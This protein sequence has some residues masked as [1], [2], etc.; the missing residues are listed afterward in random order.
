MIDMKDPSKTD[1]TLWQIIEQEPCLHHQAKGESILHLSNGY[2]GIR[3]AFEENYTGQTRGLFV[4]GC[5]DRPISEPVEL[6]NAADT[7][8]IDL[9]LDGEMF[10]MCTGVVSN[11]SRVLDMSTGL[12]TRTLC[13]QSPLGRVYDLVFQKFVSRANLNLYALRI[14][15]TARNNPVSI[16]ITHGINA[17]M[18]NS[19]TQHF[20]DGLKRVIDGHYLYLEQ[21]TLESRFSFSHGTVLTVPGIEPGQ[22]SYIMDRRIIRQTLRFDIKANQPVVL[23]KLSSIHTTRTPQNQM[24]ITVQTLKQAAHK[25]FDLLLAES[26]AILSRYWQENEIALMTTTPALVR[27]LRYAQFSLLSMLPPDPHSSI[28]AKG[29]SGEG[30]RGHVFWDTEIFML[31][32]FLHTNP[33][34]ARRLLQYRLDRMDQARDNAIQNGYRGLMFPWESAA[35]GTEETPKYA[36]MNILTGKAAR[37]W[38]GDKEHHI[39]ADIAYA[40][41]HYY[42][43]TEDTDFLC[44]GGA[45]L[46]IGCA[47]FWLSRSTWIPE[48]NRF[49]ILDIIGPDEYTEHIDNN[50]YSNYLAAQTVTYA[51]TVLDCLDDLE[52]QALSD[53]FGEPDIKL[54]LADFQSR[55]YLPQPGVD[56]VIPQDDTFLAKP[57]LEIEP[58]K[59]SDIKQSILKHYSRSQVNDMQ[60]LKQPDVLMLI[61]LFP[62]LFEPSVIEQNWRYYE[63]KTIQDSSLSTSVHAMTACLFGDSD[64]AYRSYLQAIEIDLGPNL[65][66]SDAGV[67]AAAMGG[68]W[69]ALIHGFAGIHAHGSVLSIR[70]C[71]PDAIRRITLPFVWKG[72]RLTIQVARDRVSVEGKPHSPIP[73]R[74]AAKDYVWT[75]SL[76]VPLDWNEVAR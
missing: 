71:L 23:E 30:Y 48:R 14:G 37:V 21:T 58:F 33:E 25:G 9:I 17:R 54:H 46:L 2:V 72:V 20:D 68:I 7:G 50:A 13:W 53:Y 67:H 69:F 57:L 66:S 4:T 45:R 64:L 60:V 41:W 6:P 16:Q 32:Y 28:A 52:V 76:S 27:A 74:I 36:S 70:P 43:A 11:Y 29:L 49:E 19:G 35:T 10:S 8:A 18:T 59:T 34:L 65:T 61:A 73:I 15:I 12:L 5:F 38:A 51:Q 56:G 62:D 26:H 39:T 40:A 75:G 22:A 47:L 63:P 3:S 1:H 42:Q 44:Q 55:L 31:P 24:D